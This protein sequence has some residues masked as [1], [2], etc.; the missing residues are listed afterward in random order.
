MTKKQYH[1]MLDSAL[2]HLNEI[3]EKTSK[4]NSSEDPTVY[5]SQKIRYF[6]IDMESALDYI[7]F[8]LFNAYFLPIMHK[9]QKSFDAIEKKQR[10]INFPNFKDEKIFNRRIKETLPRLN[11][12][13]PEILIYLKEIQPF[14][15]KSDSNHWLTLLNDLVNTNKHR[16]LSLIQQTENAKIDFMKFE[17]GDC[18]KNVIVRNVSTAIS[19]GGITLTNENAHKLGIK[20]FQGD[21]KKTLYFE[22]DHTSVEKT[23]NIIY[24]NANGTIQKLDNLIKKI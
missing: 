23:L 3:K 21:I 20:E 11:T 13:H 16:H 8:D 7:A 18:F 24:D 12:L 14:N 2:A 17:N 1:L 15:H 19:I 10:N 22:S 5:F 6:V 4:I 9:E